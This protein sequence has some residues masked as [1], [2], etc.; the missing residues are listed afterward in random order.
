MEEIQTGIAT[1]R[2]VEL[3][4]FGT[5]LLKSRKGRSKARNSKT[6]ETFTV[7]NHGAAIFRPEKELKEKV[8]G[9]R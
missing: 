5:F 4:G 2:L 3:N 1:D 8:W 9:L 7:G 6:G